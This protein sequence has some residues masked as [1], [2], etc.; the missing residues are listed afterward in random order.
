M[1]SIKKYYQANRPK[2]YGVK[3]TVD[4]KRRFKFF[5][6]TDGQ[7][8]YFEDLLKKSKKLGTSILSM[9]ADEAAIMRKCVDMVGSPESVLIACKEYAGKTQLIPCKPEKAVTEYLHEKAAL[10]RDINYHRAIRKI[11]N[12]L[13]SRFPAVFEN[14]TPEVA[15]EWAIELGSKPSS[16][17][18]VTIKNHIKGSSAFCEWAIDRRYLA[19]NPFEKTPIPDVI[20]PEPEFLSI[21]DIEKLFDTAKNNFPH[22]IAYMAIGAFAGVRSSAT[23]RLESDAI[24]FEKK[25]ILIRAQN[26]KNKRRVF[27][28]GHEPNLWLWLDWAKK[29]APHGFDLTKRQ[30][31]KVREHLYKK[32]KVKMPHNAFRHS[33]CSYHVALH[34]DAGKTATL[35]T[36]RGNVAILYEHYKG[37]ATKAEGEKYFSIVP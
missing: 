37:N 22:A 7:E 32:A 17:A 27:I 28:D 3:W 9:T 34:G 35:L 4:G 16:Y 29:N 23:A 10:G 6:T 5:A 15:R 33:F 31:D 24:D 36:H 21:A 13:T 25:G 26:A 11:L 19:I 2:P 18:P 30:W 20:M 12:R 14:W 1:S 8:E